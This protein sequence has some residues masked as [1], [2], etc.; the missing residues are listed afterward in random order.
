MTARRFPLR[1][2]FRGLAAAAIGIGVM[3]LAVAAGIA[4]DGPSRLFCLVTGGA[5]VVL[6]G[7]YLMS[8]AWRLRV[9]ADDHG[10]EVGTEREQRF[11]I[12]WREVCRVIASPSTKTCFIDTGRF[13]TSFIVPGPGARAPYAIA[14]RAALYEIVMAHAAAEVIVEVDLLERHAALAKRGS[15][16]QP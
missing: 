2:R 15:S 9:V 11:R 16:N 10:L 14:D 12:D 1:P 8:P 7:L 13:E 4:L 5:G 6:G 3:L